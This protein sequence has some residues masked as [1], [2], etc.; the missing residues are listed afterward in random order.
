MVG[1]PCFRLKAIRSVLKDLVSARTHLEVIS[2]LLFWFTVM[3]CN[4]VT[5]TGDLTEKRFFIIFLQL[6][7]DCN[8]LDEDRVAAKL[9]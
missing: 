3:S 5:M 9:H 2:E 4:W 8:L 1:F 7:T 6:E